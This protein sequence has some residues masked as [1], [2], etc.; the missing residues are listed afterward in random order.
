MDNQAMLHVGGG[1]AYAEM[2]DDARCSW[3]VQW[4]DK[5]APLQKKILVDETD[6]HLFKKMY[7]DMPG[8]TMV[9][10][11]NQWHLPGI[12]AH[13]R[14]TTG[15]EIEEEPINPLGDMPINEIMES[16]L[17]NDALS[18]MYSKNTK[19][20]AIGSYQYMTHYHKYCQEYE[21]ARHAVFW[22]Y[23][24]PHL[25]HSVYLGENDHVE[26]LPYDVKGHH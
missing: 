12:E 14:H 23:K 26:N 8:K 3:W 25:E 15:T 24:D 11:V 6:A 2:L 17:V 13:W 20:E 16:E 19:S 18:R 21:R 9:A 22:D 4:F 10:V 1:E 7:N 5:C